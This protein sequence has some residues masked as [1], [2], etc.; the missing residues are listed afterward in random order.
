LWYN[1]GGEESRKMSS[2][3]SLTPREYQAL[4]KIKILVN[5]MFQI[6][7]IVLFGSVTRGE[8][9]A[10]SDIDLGVTKMSFNLPCI[11]DL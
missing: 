2:V 9:D 6:E 1:F 4:H 5:Q 3:E 11:V 10:E 7:Q 8:A